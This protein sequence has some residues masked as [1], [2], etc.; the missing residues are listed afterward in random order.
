MAAAHAHLDAVDFIKAAAIV[1]VV[2]THS[3][4]NVFYPN[5]TRWDEVLT[6]TWTWFHV[7]SF[8]LVSGF[9][10]QSE[11]RVGL[12]DVARRLSRVW[13]PYVLATLF[14]QA[15]GTTPVPVTGV[16]DVLYQIA[17]ASALGPYYYVALISGCI[18]ALWPLSRLAP[19]GAAA[20]LAALFAY[21]VALVFWPGLHLTT[22]PLWSERNP[23]D[24][25]VLG[26][27][28]LG[29]VAAQHRERLAR[30]LA[31]QRLPI[32][33]VAA[34]GA[35]F[36]FASIGRSM[37]LDVVNLNRVVYTLSVVALILVLTH[38]RRAP[39]AV[40]FLSTATLTIYLYH[41]AA[42]LPAALFVNAWSPP[43]RISF[44]LALGIG[45]GSLV[46]IV[47]RRVLGAERARR[48]LG[49]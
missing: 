40:V 38:G 1:A 8:L 41:L 32:G 16:G 5:A 3:G 13:I 27:F 6:S 24:A 21:A 31:A 18:L 48:Y 44:Q 37:N 47:G 17:T 10:Y 43:L 12:R 22:S 49:A 34:A 33:C 26:Y 46:A 11:R 25:F 9:L 28:V 35:L 39:R 7:P 29:W 19:A 2:A 36:W 15:T 14:M 23:L 30:I 20:L 45:F 42:Q 4:I